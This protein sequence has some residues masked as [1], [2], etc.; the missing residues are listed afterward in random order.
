MEKIN[1]QAWLS[2]LKESKTK[3]SMPILSFPSVQLMGLSVNEMLSTAESQAKAMQLVAEKTPSLAAVGFMDLSVEAECFGSNIIFQDNEIPTVSGAIV[4]DLEEAEALAVPKV[5]DKR[6][7]LYIDAIKIASQTINDRPVFAGAIGSFSLA[8]RLLDVTEALMCCYTDPDLLHTVLKKSTEFIIEYVKAFKRAGANGV[9]IAEPL[10]GLLSPDL[11]DE[12]ST[13]YVKKIVEEAQDEFFTVIYHNCGNTALQIIDSI[14]KTEAGAYHF[15]NAI[16]ICDILKSVPSN[17][18]VMGNIDPVEQFK[19]G[20]PES[21]K[22]AV[23][24]LLSR[25]ANYKNFVISSGCDIPPSASWN[26]INAYYE[27]IE[28]YYKNPVF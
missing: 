15:G 10:T 21:M 27:A 2:E 13:P 23:K 6:S 28:E 20:T 22:Q 18:I 26:N 5:G 19:N 16:D 7:G 11:A 17:T 12:F 14:L 1:M 3:K 4:N 25:C 9:I 24:E 8:G